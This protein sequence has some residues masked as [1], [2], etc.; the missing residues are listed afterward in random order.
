MEKDSLLGS[1][2]MRPHLFYQQKQEQLWINAHVFYKECSLKH[3]HW[4]QGGSILPTEKN[5]SFR[6]ILRNWD[7]QK[8]EDSLESYEYFLKV[9]F[10]FFSSTLFSHLKPHWVLLCTQ[11]KDNYLF[12]D[13]GWMASQTKWHMSQVLKDA[14]E[15]SRMGMLLPGTGSKMGKTSKTQTNMC[16]KQDMRL[17]DQFVFIC[18]SNLGYQPP[19]N[20]TLS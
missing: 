3:S 18:F 10:F 2:K 6:A 12:L 14:Q 8:Y 19:I 15:P 20:N 9:R 7:A 1:F 4:N 13:E 17:A 16:K 5:S 11:N